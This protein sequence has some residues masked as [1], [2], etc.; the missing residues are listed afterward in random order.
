M[1]ISSGAGG[2]IRQYPH[3]APPRQNSDGRLQPRY[4]RHTDNKDRPWSADSLPPP[5]HP[6]YVSP[7]SLPLPKI[8]SPE[9]RRRRRKRKRKKAFVD[10]DV[11]QASAPEEE[12]KHSRTPEP[13][14]RSRRK[15]ARSVPAK[16][17]NDRENTKK[18]ILQTQNTPNKTEQKTEK[19]DSEDNVLD[20]QAHD[21]AQKET[22][23]TASDANEGDNT[24]AD[25][26]DVLNGNCSNEEDAA[27]DDV[28][29]RDT[30]DHVDDTGSD[31]E[32]V[33]VLP[34]DDSPHSDE[35][36]KEKDNDDGKT[37]KEEGRDETQNGNEM[38]KES[39]EKSEEE[40]PHQKETPQAE[41]H[42]DTTSA[43]NEEESDG[44][45]T[46]ADNE[47]TAEG[48]QTKNPDDDNSHQDEAKSEKENDDTET[49]NN[50]EE[51][52]HCD[53]KETSEDSQRKKP[54]RERWRMIKFALAVASALRRRNP[55]KVQTV[56]KR[57]VVIRKVLKPK[58]GTGV[59]EESDETGNNTDE[60]SH[61]KSEDDTT[62]EN[63]TRIDVQDV[64]IKV[65]G[66]M[67]VALN[68]LRIS[69]Q[70]FGVWKRSP[71]FLSNHFRTPQRSPRKRS[72]HALTGQ[73]SWWC[74]SA[75]SQ[76]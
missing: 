61:E 11:D 47:K 76:R 29:A 68:N 10:P 24:G 31:D 48:S 32:N 62:E 70:S 27:K 2:W 35:R 38:S 7:Y 51:E 17:Q 28:N 44:I 43:K 74:A 54:A 49:K 66:T 18:K 60:A 5:Y 59:C 9:P 22:A 1:P 41:D 73:S 34:D 45:K 40:N 50:G 16:L 42:E 14:P 30:D 64:L 4:S 56:K 55:R 23:N 19:L 8:P 57:K 65:S 36:N 15:R 25:D 21:D 6:D 37:N 33:A 12:N 63:Q 52:R 72:G 46:Q 20:E 53:N 71:S 39:Q 13:S 69:R 58:H 75:L 3:H 67:F 26:G